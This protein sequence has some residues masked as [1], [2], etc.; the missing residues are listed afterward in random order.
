M[1]YEVIDK[2]DVSEAAKAFYREY[3]AG[4]YIPYGGWSEEDYRLIRELNLA[5]LITVSLHR[6]DISDNEGDV[7]SPPPGDRTNPISE[8]APALPGF[9]CLVA[10]YGIDEGVRRY[11]I[12]EACPE[13]EATDLLASAEQSKR[14]AI[15]PGCPPPDHLEPFSENVCP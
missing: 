15:L 6:V 8:N 11:Q 4:I 2:A 7:P 14:S 12:G 9:R 1:N 3:L 13:R 10:K 5:G